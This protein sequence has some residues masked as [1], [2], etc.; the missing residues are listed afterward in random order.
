MRV[1]KLRLHATGQYFL[2][3]HKKT[4]YLGK[5]KIPAEKEYR[6]YLVQHLGTHPLESQEKITVGQMLQDYLAAK[7]AATP[8]ENRKTT[9]CLL[10]HALEPT[11]RL[12]G[13]LLANSFGPL[14]F[15]TVRKEMETSNRTRQYVNK[16]CGKL[17]SAWKWGVS[18]QM[19][20]WE[21]YQELLHVPE[22]QYGQ[23]KESREAGPV[24]L[25]LVEKTL[26]YLNDR[27][28]DIVRLLLLT[29]ARPSEILR[30]RPCDVVDG[31][32]R[33]KKHKTARLNMKRAIV[34]STQAQA[35]LLKHRPPAD[36]GFY[37][38]DKL[39]KSHYR[40]RSLYHAVQRACKRAKLPEWFPY[41]IRHRTLTDISLRLG[42]EYAQ[43]V[44]GHAK[45]VT[46]QHY[47][48]SA[49]ERAK[50]AVG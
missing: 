28:A 13:H 27:N 23:L 6:R 34:L 45:A 26:P 16:L 24:D 3:I 29:G 36:D 8:E 46:T 40:S 14:A 17:R 50:K 22:L 11:K 47:D 4:Y 44:G 41:Q 37:F 33:P 7:L 30:L 12:Y 15:Q 48:H 42:R 31:V 32:Y 2:C 5:D 35:I 43:A 1:P 20:K 49:I 38:P 39:G 10:R 21:T 19:V 18:Q 9:A 25:A